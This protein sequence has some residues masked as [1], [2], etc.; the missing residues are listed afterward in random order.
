MLCERFTQANWC[1]AK[2]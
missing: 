1:P 2:F